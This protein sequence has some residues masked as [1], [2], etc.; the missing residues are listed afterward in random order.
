[1]AHDLSDASCFAELRACQS[2]LHMWGRANGVA[3]DSA[4]ESMHI[5][6]RGT[7]VGSGFVRPGTEFDSKLVVDTAAH[8][9]V[10]EC[11]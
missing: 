8:A 11:G 7:A 5:L 6:A 10:A 1:M 4:K 9:C 2:T 3:F